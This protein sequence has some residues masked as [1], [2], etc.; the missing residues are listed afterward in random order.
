MS[1]VLETENP[2][3]FFSAYAHKPQCPAPS[4]RDHMGRFRGDLNGALTAVFSTQT[5]IQKLH[6]SFPRKPL[7]L[8]SPTP[9]APKRSFAPPA[10]PSASPFG[11][12]H[13][14]PPP[15]PA[16]APSWHGLLARTPTNVLHGRQHGIATISRCTPDATV[17]VYPYSAPMICGV[18]RSPS[19]G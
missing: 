7:C 14:A 3:K 12:S 9:P 6:N 10:T 19:A 13:L 5:I 8:A 16:S 4:R 1:R 17:L 11:P 2:Q 15:Q 18:V